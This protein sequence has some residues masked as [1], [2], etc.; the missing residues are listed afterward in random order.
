MSQQII[1]NGDSGLIVRNGLNNMF[2]EI[3]ASL[4]FPI[5]AN[6]VTANTNVPIPADTFVQRIS[7]VPTSGTPT[8]RIGTTANGTDIMP[9]TVINGFQQS[10]IQE[11]FASLG[12]LYITFT[13]GSGT[14]NFRI[15]VSPTFF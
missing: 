11:Y 7:V 3:Y 13:T 10:L 9:D 1:N 5:K 4:I 15:D 2:T 14:L 12:Y 8:I 6:G